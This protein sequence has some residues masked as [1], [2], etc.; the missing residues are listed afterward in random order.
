MIIIETILLTVSKGAEKIEV[1]SGIKGSDLDTAISK[2]EDKDLKWGNWFMNT[3]VVKLTGLF[4][5][6]Q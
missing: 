5:V 2:L 4:H 6:I 3:V 1:P